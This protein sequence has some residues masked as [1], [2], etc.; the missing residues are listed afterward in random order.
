MAVEKK[1]ALDVSINSIVVIVFAITMLGLGLAF[2]RGKFGDIENVVTFSPPSVPATANLPIVLPSDSLS[3]NKGTSNKITVN[4][5]NDETA[6][7][8]AARPVIGSC[9]DENGASVS[10]FNIVASPLRVKVG[11]DV[12]FETTMKVASSA[13]TQKY[14]CTLQIGQTEKQFIINVK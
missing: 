13:S 6:D 1:A 14:I 12:S 3:L 9:I 10:H 4:F 11:E 2:I 5:Y 8:S 7:I